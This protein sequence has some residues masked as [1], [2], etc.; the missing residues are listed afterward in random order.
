MI[1]SAVGRHKD[2]KGTAIATFPLF[3]VFTCFHHPQCAE[4][5]LKNGS[6]IHF[7]PIQ[8]QSR[9][10]SVSN[11]FATSLRRSVFFIQVA[12]SNPHIYKP[13]CHITIYKPPC[14]ITISTQFFSLFVLS[15]SHKA[16]VATSSLCQTCYFD[17][18][19]VIQDAGALKEDCSS[20]TL[21]CFS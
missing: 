5:V 13:P 21:A 18:V 6:E 16:A 11:T 19:D 4:A 3:H 17:S 1:V 20:L 2:S 15:L 14:H 9:H 12:S 8:L 10:K 7:L